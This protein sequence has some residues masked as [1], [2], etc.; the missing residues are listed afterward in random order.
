MGAC[1]TT[2]TDGEKLRDVSPVQKKNIVENYYRTHHQRLSDEVDEE[3]KTK[4]SALIVD[5]HSF[6][7]VSYY[8]NRDFGKKRPDICI[9]TDSFHTPKLLQETVKQFFLYKGY[10]ARVDNPYSGT[11]VPLKHYKKDK[12]V[13]SIMIEVNRKLYMD[14]DGFKTEH[15]DI[16]RNELNELLSGI[17]DIY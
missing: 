17:K 16:L 8:F 10:D 2:N 11:M 15:F 7:D 13:S 4:G 12:N 9:G 14:E 6:P 3:L 1:Y 5:C